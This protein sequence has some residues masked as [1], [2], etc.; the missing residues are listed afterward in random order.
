MRSSTRAWPVPE[1]GLH[2]LPDLLIIAQER[3]E[4]PQRGNQ[5]L[6]GALAVRHLGTRF[7][8]AEFPLRL[9]GLRHDATPTVRVGSRPPSGI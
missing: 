8:F 2:R 6:V 5:P 9:R 1:P 3:L 4:E 7:L